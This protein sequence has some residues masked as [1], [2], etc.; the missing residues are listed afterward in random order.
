M[1]HEAKAASLALL[2]EM[3]TIWSTQFAK[4]ATHPFRETK[5]GESDPSMMFMLVHFVAERWREAL[6]WSWVVAK[7]GA[8]D[9]AWTQGIADKAWA[10]L[11][12]EVRQAK[13]DVRAK[14]RDSLNLDRVSTNLRASG[15][16]QVD[17]TRYEFCASHFFYFC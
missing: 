9:D 17:T 15:H 8:V 1:T 7:H 6:L 5:A 10:E 3:S 4:T 14:T 13:V 11:G 16:K 12:G 2:H